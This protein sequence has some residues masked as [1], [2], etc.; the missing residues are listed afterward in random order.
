[1]KF[2]S[3]YLYS[4]IT[5]PEGDMLLPRVLIDYT[6]AIFPRVLIDYTEVMFRDDFT[7]DNVR[8]RFDLRGKRGG[9]YS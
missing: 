4:G 1:M 5:Q 8:K 7:I 6:E 2:D 3:E 9:P